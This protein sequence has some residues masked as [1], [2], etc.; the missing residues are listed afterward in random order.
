MATRA[1]LLP[2]EPQGQRSLAAVYD[3]KEA[4]TAE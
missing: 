4:G 3:H 2:G 1:T